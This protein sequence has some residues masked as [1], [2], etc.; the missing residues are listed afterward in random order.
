MQ[1]PKA[2]NNNEAILTMMADLEKFEEK[3][4]SSN[5]VVVEAATFFQKRVEGELKASMAQ[6][7]TP[8]PTRKPVVEEGQEEVSE[9]EE[10]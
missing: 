1:A 2:S 3:T 5:Q 4:K 8:T 10:E 6:P 7:A 9:E